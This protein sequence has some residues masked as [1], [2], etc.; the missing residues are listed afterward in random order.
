QT[1]TCAIIDEEVYCWG[2]SRRIGLDAD[3]YINLPRHLPGLTG[4]ISIEAG[5]FHTC[6]LINNG[7]FYCWGLNRNLQVGEVED[8]TVISPRKINLGTVQIK[9]FSLGNGTNPSLGRTCV[10]ASD[11]KVYCWGTAALG[12]FGSISSFLA[13][14]FTLQSESNISSLKISS[15]T[16]CYTKDNLFYGSG[17]NDYNQFT[18]D[19]YIIGE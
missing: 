2:L 9:S 11:R 1:H 3:G 6:A 17:Y 12:V 14:S 19:R 8:N 15:S 4:A 16:V 13:K 5:D 7:D 18:H 10:L